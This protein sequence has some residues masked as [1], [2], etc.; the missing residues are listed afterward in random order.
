[1]QEKKQVN[2]K[3]IIEYYGSTSPYGKNDVAHQR[4]LEDLVLYIAK[5]CIALSAVENP[6]LWRLRL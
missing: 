6:W 2:P 3:A 5:G 1:M 4:F